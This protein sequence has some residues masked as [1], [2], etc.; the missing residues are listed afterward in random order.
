MSPD[1]DGRPPGRR[2]ASR[3][4]SNSLSTNGLREEM[5]PFHLADGRRA[6]AVLPVVP[7]AAPYQVRE[8]IARRRI[9]ALTGVCPCGARVDYTAVTV[10]AEVVEVQHERLCP[11]QTA[12]LVKAIRRWAR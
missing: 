9:T 10:A 6:L 2:R 3:T 5:V 1:N 7:E 12:R 4:G 11:A 8:G